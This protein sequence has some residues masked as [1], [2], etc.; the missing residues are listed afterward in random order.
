MHAATD[1]G[2]CLEHLYAVTARCRGGGEAQPGRACTYNTNIALLA[3][4]QNIE[5]TD[6]PFFLASHRRILDTGDFTITDQARDTDVRADTTNDFVFTAIGAFSDDEW[7]GHV[8]P[9]HRDHV[10]ITGR[11]HFLSLGQVEEAPD[12]KNLRAIAGDP[13]RPARALDEKPFRYRTHRCN[14]DV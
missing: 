5:C 7:I 2:A 3:G 6:A 13:L 1:F 14:C 4:R 10:G 12:H 8:R 9:R 11:E